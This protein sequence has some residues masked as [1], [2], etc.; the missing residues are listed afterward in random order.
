MA[1]EAEAS[2]LG[3]AREE[4]RDL[5]FGFLSSWAMLI[6]WPSSLS[7]SAATGSG[8]SDFKPVILFV[9]TMLIQ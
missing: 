6:Q 3:L 9:Y 5:D 4:S 8:S 7:W 2:D 1:G